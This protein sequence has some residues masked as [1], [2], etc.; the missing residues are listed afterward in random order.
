MALQI[1]LLLA[2][3]A[4][5]GYVYHQLAIL[6]GLGMAGIALGSMAGHGKKWR[7]PHLPQPS[8][9]FS[10]CL[11]RPGPCSSAPV[12][13]LAGLSGDAGTWTAAQCVFPAL[14][15]LC[16]VLGGYQFP[17]AA[18]IFL[19]EAERRRSLGTLYAVDLAGRMCLRDCARHVPHSRVRLLEDG[20]ALRSHQL[21]ACSACRASKQFGTS[22][23]TISRLGL[24][25]A[26]DHRREAEDVG[27]LSPSSNRCHARL[28]R[29]SARETSA[30]PIS[31]STGT[32]GSSRPSESPFFISRPC[33]PTLICFD[34]ERRG[35]AARARRFHIQGAATPRPYRLEARIAQGGQ[36]GR[37]AH[38][39]VERLDRRRCSRCSRAARRRSVSVTNAPRSWLSVIALRSRRLIGLI[40]LDH[41]LH[42][43]ARQSEQFAFSRRRSA[44]TASRPLR[45]Y[46]AFT[47]MSAL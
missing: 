47:K 25:L 9:A 31:A 44:K 15:A 3:Q 41:V 16:G 29:R 28:A 35:A 5:Y 40:L 4:I 39:Q 32:C 2:F 20:V 45:R 46:A 37:V 22:D 34:I 14:A 19:S 6:I 26:E 27:V 21:C 36:R 7:Q 10:F 24:V 38:G 11:R 8:P 43:L 12:S 17:M 30:G 18:R 42:R 23:A 1:F 33:S 13:L